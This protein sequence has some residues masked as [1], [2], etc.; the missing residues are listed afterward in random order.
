M[1]VKLVTEHYL[2]FLRLTGDCTD[3][4]ECAL[5]KKVELLAFLHKPFDCSL[6]I[7]D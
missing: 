3:S 1:T 7:A 2:E 6:S 5:V 4:S